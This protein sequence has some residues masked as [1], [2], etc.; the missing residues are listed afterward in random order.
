VIPGDRVAE[1]A[2]RLGAATAVV[3]GH[4]PGLA[5]AL[6]A[7]GLDVAESAGGGDRRYDVLVW[8]PGEGERPPRPP[9]ALNGLADDVLVIE[10][11]APAEWADGFAAMGFRLEAERAPGVLHFR[12]SGAAPDADELRRELLRRVEQM[13]GLY[14]LLEEK[15]QVIAALRRELG[16]LHATLGWRALEQLRAV[17]A[18][19][20]R[21]PVLRTGYTT[22]R[23]AVEI[24]VEDGARELALKTGHKLGLALRGRDF[25]VQARRAVPRAVDDQYQLWL[26][27]ERRGL[28]TRRT[29][30]GHEEPLVSVLAVLDAPDEALVGRGVQTLRAQTYARWELCLAAGGAVRVALKSEL[31]ALEGEEPR[32]RVA[33]ADGEEATIADAFRAARGTLIGVLDLRDG[34]APEALTELAGRLADDPAVDLAYSDEDAL[35]ASGRRREPFFKPEWSPSLLLGTD[36]LGRFALV[37]R[38]LVEA[39]GGPRAEAGTAAGYDLWLRVSELTDRIVRIPR[40]LAHRGPRTASVA[41]V[42][43]WERV[44][45]TERRAIEDALR[46]RGL[47]GEVAVV[48]APFGARSAFGPR[49]RL[50]ERPLV[51]III[52]TRDKR[53]LLEQTIRSVQERTAYD[54]YEI[55]VVDNE[56]R[57]P[58][59]LRFLEGLGP[60]CR[61]LRWP[62]AFNFSAINN[63]GARHAAGE[64]VLFL[65]NDVE[66]LRPDWLTALLE[67]AQRPEVGAVG[68]KLLYPDGRIQHAG[69]VV[70]VSG[71][72]VHAFRLWPGEPDGAP[73]LADVI[74]ECTA[75][76][77]ACMLVPRRVFEQVGGF[78]ERLRVVFNDVDLCLRIRALGL[79]VVYTPFALLLHY[80]GATRGRLHPTP[81]HKLFLQRWRAVLRATD[82]YYNPNLTDTRD[83]WS[84]RL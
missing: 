60:P 43:T 5:P 82:P 4:V 84:L 29:G 61:V 58:E 51:S 52:P 68:A 30:R 38:S 8:R 75:V 53:H 23:R 83:D 7:R 49:L 18:R 42:D 44:V 37:R 80:E 13:D 34:L 3:L 64:Q 65:N 40:V 41:A 63:F 70:G 21:V 76:T 46:R 24:L 73:R 47:E 81:D 9:A 31:E 17:R 67:Q 59:T 32:V 79:Q 11:G 28:S 20:L 45:A 14:R 10:G 16:A 50:R 78:D 54:R 6:R 62:A 48:A 69:V 27:H 33:P 77:A 71:A 57:E 55:I 26:E 36:Y 15:E 35:D 39:A 12:R 22:L 19:L 56:S 74:R 72:A 66:V 2:V 1:V 25:R